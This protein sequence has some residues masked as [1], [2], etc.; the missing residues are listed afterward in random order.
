PRP[1]AAA[2]HL[3]ALHGEADFVAA[4]IAGDDLHLG[5]E[6]AVDDT[7][8]LVGVGRGAG[9]ADDQLPRQQILEPGDAAGAPGDAD[10]DLVVGAADP[11][12]FGRVELRRFVA[13]QRIEA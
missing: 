7:R 3:A 12:V 10:A 11:V 9:A 13:Q 4:R 5:A 6:H 8:K 2:L 1:A